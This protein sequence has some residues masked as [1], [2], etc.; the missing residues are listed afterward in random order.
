MSNETGNKPNS[1]RSPMDEVTFVLR[2]RIGSLNSFLTAQR[3]EIN[4][5][6]TQLEPIRNQKQRTDIDEVELNQPDELVQK[7][8]GQSVFIDELLDDIREIQSLSNTIFAQTQLLVAFR[9]Q[10]VL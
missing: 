7:L 8:E 1:E 5:L 10:L 3:Q 9:N 2:E 6:G 4:K